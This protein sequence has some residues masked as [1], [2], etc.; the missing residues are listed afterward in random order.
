MRNLRIILIIALFCLPFRTFA[1]YAYKRFALEPVFGTS[2][3]ETD[4]ESKFTPTYGAN[5]RYSLSPLITFSL[6]YLQGNWKDHKDL[7]GRTFES[8]Y[9]TMGVRAQVN[10][11]ELFRFDHITRKFHPYASIGFTRIQTNVTGIR[12]REIITNV[13]RPFKG[14]VNGFP[15]GIGT[16][17]YLS[18]KFDLGVHVE[19][20]LHNSDSIDG[21]SLDMRVYNVRN[22]PDYIWFVTTSLSYK[23]GTRKQKG[24]GHIDWVSPRQNEDQEFTQLK[25]ENY[26]VKSELDS[27]KYIVQMISEKQAETDALL[28]QILSGKDSIRMNPP[29]VVTKTDSLK[30]ES[31]NVKASDPQASVLDSTLLNIIFRAFES[32]GMRTDSLAGAIT[33]LQNNM[34]FFLLGYT[35]KY[36]RIKTVTDTKLR[37]MVPN[38]KAR[39]VKV[40]PAGSAVEFT[41]YVTKGELI[42]GNPNWYKD[43]FGNY[44]W[45]GS[46]SQPWPEEK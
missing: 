41:G 10:L 28:R 9:Y 33:E 23:F 39:I 46:T 7:I 35:P 29:V 6:N 5:F 20:L 4:P 25:E 38:T 13:A 42:E 31:E 36:G 37:E 11:G 27:L 19:Y 15:A 26:L 3:P 30:A 14:G 40:L 22:N 24:Q 12:E 2:K 18:P 34:N 43:V 21:H 1:Q 45:A 32:Q 44:F 17:I 16:R 8:K